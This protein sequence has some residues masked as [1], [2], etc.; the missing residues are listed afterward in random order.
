MGHWAH[1][2][3]CGIRRHASVGLTG[4]EGM[5]YYSVF[6]VDEERNSFQLLTLGPKSFCLFDVSNEKQ[7]YF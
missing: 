5:S 6:K 1:S 2:R 7:N 3:Y 4:M